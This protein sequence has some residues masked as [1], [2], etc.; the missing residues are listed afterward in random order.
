MYG[1]SKKV[2]TSVTTLEKVGFSFDHFCD[3]SLFGSQYFNSSISHVLVMIGHN[4]MQLAH[5]S[6][7]P[8]TFD[9]KKARRPSIFKIT[10]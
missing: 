9:G 7:W 10:Q 4:I 3:Q 6:C 1:P 8:T 5:A 2:L